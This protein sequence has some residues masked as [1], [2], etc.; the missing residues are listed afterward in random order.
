MLHKVLVQITCCLFIYV[1][2]RSAVGMFIEHGD[3]LQSIVQDTIGNPDKCNDMTPWGF[4]EDNED[5]LNSK[6]S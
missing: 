6:E 3:E 1:L 5:E 2:I 4:C